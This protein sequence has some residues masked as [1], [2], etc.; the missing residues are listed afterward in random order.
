MRKISI[1]MFL[2]YIPTLFSQHLIHNQ[3]FSFI[4]FIYKMRERHI[5]KLAFTNSIL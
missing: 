2:Y 3:L 4:N 5:Q 1:K